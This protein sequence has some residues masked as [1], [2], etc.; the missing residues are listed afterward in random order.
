VGL[1]SEVRVADKQ[2]RALLPG[3]DRVLSQPAPDRR[4]RRLR[5]AALDHQTVQLS[6]REAPERQA[7][8]GRQLAGDRLD[9]G[10]LLRGENGAGDPRA[11]CPS[12]RP[13][14]RP[15]TAFA[16]AQP[17]RRRYQ[18]VRRSRDRTRPPRHKARS[19][20]AAH[21]E[22]AASPPEPPAPAPTAPP[23]SD[24]SG[25]EPGVPS[26]P[27]FTAPDPTPSTKFRPILPATRASGPGRLRARL[28]PGRSYGSGRRTCRPGGR[29][30]R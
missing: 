3:L 26:P 6:A 8:R 17:D 12:D 14:A 30:R 11:A 28:W 5:D 18:A 25:D 13:D 19:G 24:Q 27:Q 9:F 1:G 7:V 16:N 20:R 23:R 10:D 2:P 29:L 22:T 15:Q 4:R 21:P